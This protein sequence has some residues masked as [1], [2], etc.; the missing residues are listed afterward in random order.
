MPDD[1]STT[2]SKGINVGAIAGGVVGGAAFLA[3]CV[4][5]GVFL[6]RRRRR[7]EASIEPF[8]IEMGPTLQIQRLQAALLECHPF[9][10]LSGTPYTKSYAS[11]SGDRVESQQIDQRGSQSSETVM[12]M[13]HSMDR[14]IDGLARPPEYS[15]RG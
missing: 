4:L 12:Q 7:K 2:A 9:D 6:L 11:G 1:E 3:V 14:R 5:V 8:A 15:E 10:W 13:L